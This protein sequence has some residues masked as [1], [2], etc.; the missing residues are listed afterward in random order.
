MSPRREFI[1]VNEWPTLKSHS[2]HVQVINIAADKKANILKVSL[3]NLDPGQL[4]R[5]H[6][7][8]LPLAVHPGSRTSQFL[9][10]CGIEANECGTR[11]Y[12]DAIAQSHLAV[13][14][15]KSGDVVEFNHIEKK[16]Q[17]TNSGKEH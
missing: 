15:T 12:L 17:E 14:F 10:A 7:I 4:G 1:V 2:Y 16:S 9:M 11:V 3:N 6:E 8:E 5:I 13:K